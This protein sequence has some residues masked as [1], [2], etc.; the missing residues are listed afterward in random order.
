[1]MFE[2]LRLSTFLLACITLR[3]G[4]NVVGLHAQFVWCPQLIFASPVHASANAQ[5]HA[6]RRMQ[7]A[8]GGDQK[9]ADGGHQRAVELAPFDPVYSD[10][11]AD[12]R[13]TQPSVTE[14]SD[15]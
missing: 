8:Q 10:F 14:S 4:L 15:Y 9:G 12:I 5:D 7:L 3:L 2:M 1:M 11:L 13:G 6:D